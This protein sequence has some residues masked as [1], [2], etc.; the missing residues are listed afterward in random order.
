LPLLVTIGLLAVIM[1]I[2]KRTWW[3]KLKDY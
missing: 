3:N 2:L 1:M